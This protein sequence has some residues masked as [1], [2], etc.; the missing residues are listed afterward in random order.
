MLVFQGEKQT[1]PMN[2]GE[3]FRTPENEDEP[4]MQMDKVWRD[5]PNLETHALRKTQHF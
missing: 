5:E 1:H 2:S 4:K 3:G